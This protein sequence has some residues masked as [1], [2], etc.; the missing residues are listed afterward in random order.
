MRDQYHKIII[1][2]LISVSLAHAEEERYLVGERYFSQRQYSKALP[3]LEDEARKGSR[4]AMYR[5]AYMYEKGLGVQRDAKIS[6]YWYKQAGSSYSYV[7]KMQQSEMQLKK[8]PSIIDTLSEQME[9][10]TDK[11]SAAYTLTRMDTDTPETKKIAESYL[12]GDFFGLYPY[13]SNYILPVS[14]ASS[15]YLRVQTDTPASQEDDHYNKNTEVEFQLSLKKPITYDLFGWNESI[16]AAYTQKV[17]WQLYDN[18]GPFRETNYLPELFLSV[19]MSDYMDDTYGIKAFRLG[20]IHESNGQ[21][22]YRSRS[23]NRFYLTGL[24]QW[25]DLFLASRVWTRLNEDRKYDGYY[26]GKADPATGEVDPNA[27]GDDNPDIEEYLGYG[28]IKIDYLYEKHQFGSLFRYNFGAGGSQHGAI[29]LNWSYP[30]FTS[31]NTFWYLK[32]FNGYG[33]SLI[34]YDR[35]VTKA[36]FG[37]SFS[38]GLY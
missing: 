31:K 38:R 13:Q 30:F 24:W 16:V 4:P 9:L 22:G 35:P 34:D 23:W 32:F 20:F 33:E 37:F 1:L 6:A 36:A 12:G 14:I 3:L 17:W 8:E 2:L 10:D 18:S 26:D 15:R 11:E 28:D 27:S 21:E 7:V 29:E 5:L 25:K 19:P